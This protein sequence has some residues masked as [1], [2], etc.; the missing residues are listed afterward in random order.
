[1]NMQDK[2]ID[3]LFRSKL[4]DFEMEPS[5]GAWNKISANLGETKTK[6][7]IVPLLRIAASVVVLLT[8]GLLFLNRNTANYNITAG[9]KLSSNFKVNQSATEPK[10][11]EQVAVL[12]AQTLQTS[13][14][15][16]ASVQ[17]QLAR[18][19]AARHL[20]ISQP[21]KVET[22]SK[23]EVSESA[24]TVIEQKQKEQEALAAVVQNKTEVS[25][26]V[27][28]DIKLNTA[29]AIA[30]QPNTKPAVTTTTAQVPVETT[31]KTKKRGFRSFGD[32]VNAVVAKVDKRADK[33]IE[34]TNTDD[35]E[36]TITGVNLGI[37]KVK[38]EK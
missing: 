21:Q 26:P 17:A 24:P 4:A 31:G 6:K 18:V 5:A 16:K 35:D 25:N 13:V 32:M 30:D 14:K 15:S 29:S 1:M 37:I 20:K 8:A 9:R 3:E 36:S 22:P 28:P 34:F 2:E 27:V 23:P 33:V 12:Q 19:T 10:S 7:R 11:Q 38:K